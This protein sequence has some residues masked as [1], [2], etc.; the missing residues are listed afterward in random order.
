MQP[1]DEKTLRASFVNT[2]RKELSDLTLP[3]GFET[4]DFARLDYLGWRDRRIARRAYAVVPVGPDGDDG[5]GPGSTG[6]AGVPELIGVMLKQAEASPRTRAQ[7]SLCQDVQLPNDVVLFSA[8][9]SGPAGR[10]GNTIASLVCSSFECSTNVRKLPATAYVGFDV[11]A[12]RTD[13]IASLRTRVAAFAR[14]VLDPA[15]PP[16][17]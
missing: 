2:S 13:R 4:L 14:A 9:R 3:D 1:L 11:E 6:S 17:S 8:R 5:A 7:C 12:A 10:N 16:T 15:A